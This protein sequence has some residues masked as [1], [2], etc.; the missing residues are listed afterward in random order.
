MTA[1][2]AFFRPRGVAFVGATEDPTK[3]GGRRYRSLVEEGFAGPIYPIHPRAER[4][5]GL[6][7]YRSVLDV[8]DP[9][10]LAV[11]VVPR[12]VVPQILADCARRAIPGVVCITAGFGEVDAS[13][14]RIEKR[15]VEAYRASGGRLLG[16]NCAG[17]FDAASNLNLGATTVPRGPVSLVSQSGNLLLDFSQH[18][19]E[20]GLGFCRQATFGNAADLGAPNTFSR[21][22]HCAKARDAGG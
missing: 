13:G 21:R 12:D 17:L 7:V 22:P 4:L 19:R 18:A 8:P 2:D 9:V 16:P 15:M 1:L 10:D 11:V 3:L 20:R 6:P 5:R 14:R